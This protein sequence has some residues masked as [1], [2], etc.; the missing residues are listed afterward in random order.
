MESACALAGAKAVIVM[1][2]TGCGAIKGAIDGVV[3]GNLTLLLA[4]FKS[5]LQASAYTGE[6]TSKNYAFVDA[7]AATHVKQSVQLVRARS[8]VLADLE[9]KGKIKIVGSMYDI[10]SGKVTLI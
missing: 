9:T 8:P 3:L 6:R 7:D 5:A 4:R 10:T 2:H 1:G